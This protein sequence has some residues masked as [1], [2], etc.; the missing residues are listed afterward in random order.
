M[1]TITLLLSIKINYSNKINQ[2]FKNFG[3]SKT[4][5]DLANCIDRFKNLFF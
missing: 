2:V 4:K 1:N 3:F 5:Q